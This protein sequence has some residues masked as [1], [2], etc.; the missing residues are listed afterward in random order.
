MEH[1]QRSAPC[2]LHFYKLH[3]KNGGKYHV[4]VLAVKEMKALEENP[5]RPEVD[6]PTVSS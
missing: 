2:S 3:F 5:S 4:S 6:V 1:T